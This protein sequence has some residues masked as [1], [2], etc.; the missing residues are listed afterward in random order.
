MEAAPDLN[1]PFIE[2]SAP[3]PPTKNSTEL[4]ILCKNLE[5]KVSL[6]PPGV[7]EALCEGRSI[8]DLCPKAIYVEE[9]LEIARMLGRVHLLNFN[10]DC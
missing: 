2:A 4:K 10:A 7:V 6:T 1:N 9:V 3:S 8:Y 5:K